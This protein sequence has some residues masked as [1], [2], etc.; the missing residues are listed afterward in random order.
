MEYNVW[1]DMT[2]IHIYFYCK[3]YILQSRGLNWHAIKEA[4][5][6][7]VDC[8]RWWLWHIQHPNN[9]HIFF[10][11]VSNERLMSS[12]GLSNIGI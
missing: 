12:S 8:D 7:V 4:L 5:S 3:I 6:P 11:L 2:D 10:N 9:I 1:H